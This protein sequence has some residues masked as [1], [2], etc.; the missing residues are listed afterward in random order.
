MPS[1][2]EELTRFRRVRKHL[3]LP[4]TEFPAVLYILAR[5]D[6][7]T[8]GPLHIR[9]NNADLPPVA[10]SKPGV[11]QWYA[12][13]VSP[14]RLRSGD[15]CFELWTESVAMDGWT[16]AL[17]A[18]HG[19]PGSERSDD[20][21]VN[22]R[23]DRMGYLNNVCAE[24]VLRIRLAEGED[25]PPATLPLED[26]K[27]ARMQALRDSLPEAVQRKVPPLERIRTIST[28]LGSSW[29]HTASNRAE[30]YG[31]WEVETIL[32]WGARRQGHNGK[33]PI[34]M[35]VHYAAAMVSVAQAVGLSARCAVLTEAPNGSAG[36]FVAEVWVPELEK[37]IVVDPNSDTL[38]VRH[39]IPMSMTEIQDAGADVGDHIEFGPGSEF[40]LGFSHMV[41]FCEKN[42]KKGVCFQHRSVWYRADLLTRPEFSPPGHGSL[43]YCET[44]LIW[45]Q[46]DLDRGFGMFPSFGSPEFFNSPPPPP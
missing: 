21:G 12:I 1:L 8:H 23:R 28:W 18:G 44:G 25:P 38:F 31:P 10:A 11:Y 3:D 26:C 16:L 29:E 17:E 9:V 2:G 5:P 14:D 7:Q 20:A 30:Q 43:S 40:Q 33:R 42:L 34:V 19:R 35:C 6:P 46:R 27:S 36:H 15:N 41:E 24:Y 37:W 4:A 13:E 39:G 32:A 45:E 22:W